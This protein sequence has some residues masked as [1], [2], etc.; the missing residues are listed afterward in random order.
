MKRVVLDDSKLCAMMEFAARDEERTFEYEK[1]KDQIA[2]ELS[3][4][5]L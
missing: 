1:C 5:R 3:C 2:Q 4:I